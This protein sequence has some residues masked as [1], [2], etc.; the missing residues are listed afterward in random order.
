MFFLCLE[1]EKLLRPYQQFPH[2]NTVQE[3][4]FPSVLYPAQLAVY[5]PAAMYTIFGLFG[6]SAKASP[7]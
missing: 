7:P 5:L 1:S 6:S 2:T 3:F 4:C